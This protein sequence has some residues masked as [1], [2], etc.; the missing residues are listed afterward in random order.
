MAKSA[1]PRKNRLSRTANR[2]RMPLPQLKLMTLGSSVD[3]DY[4]VARLSRLTSAGATKIYLF[5]KYVA[6]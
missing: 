6:G 1:Q 3:S 4:C 2:G 5:G